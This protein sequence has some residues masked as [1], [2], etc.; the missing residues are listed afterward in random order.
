MQ[1]I[2][3]F[4]LS[5]GSKQPL[6]GCLFIRPQTVREER[7]NTHVHRQ[8]VTPCLFLDHILF[9]CTR[10]LCQRSSYRY[11]DIYTSWPEPCNNKILKRCACLSVCGR[12][13][14]RSHLMSLYPQ[15]KIKVHLSLE[16]S[17]MCCAG[18]QYSGGPTCP[19]HTLSHTLTLTH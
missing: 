13:S 12:N 7:R 10:Q 18:N 11:V 19:L 8:S 1:L 4:P 2:L 3:L 9:C 6:F 16:S 17:F 14:F 5:G 15:S